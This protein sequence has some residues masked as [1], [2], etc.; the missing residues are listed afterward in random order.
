MLGKLI[1]YEFR[2]T[3]RYFLPIY[4]ALLLVSLLS[5]LLDA[6]S[7]YGMPLMQAILVFSYTL[8]ALALGVITLVVIITRFYRNLLGREGY[9]MFTL[10]VTVDQN[11]LAKLLPA[12]VWLVGSI[13]LLCLCMV[14]LIDWQLFLDLFDVSAWQL[15]MG[16]QGVLGAIS[17]LLGLILLMLAQILFAYMCMAIGQRFNVHKFIASVAI[18]LGLSLVLQIGLILTITFAGTVA[19]DPLAWLMTCFLETSENMQLILFC[20]FW[21]GGAFLCCLVP[22]LITRLQLKNHLNLA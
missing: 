11:I 5:G 7:Q 8:L 1:A 2:A 6:S 13:L 16:W 9:L 19:Y 15:Q 14:L 10:P 22:Y 18:Y 21:V 3:A 12:F 20:L 4:A 17:L